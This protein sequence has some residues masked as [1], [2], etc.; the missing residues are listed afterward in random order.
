MRYHNVQNDQ[1]T[2]SAAAVR[3]LGRLSLS[4]A[5][6]WPDTPVALGVSVGHAV[7][8]VASKAVEVTLRVGIFMRCI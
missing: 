2:R 1:A 4:T 3:V 6:D 7:D 8:E 5:G